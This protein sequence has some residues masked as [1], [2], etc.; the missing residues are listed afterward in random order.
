MGGLV[1]IN[2]E[3]RDIMLLQLCFNCPAL[4]FS[5]SQELCP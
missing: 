5:A 1:M 2:A 4:A 3:H